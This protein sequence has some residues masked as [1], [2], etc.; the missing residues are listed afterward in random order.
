MKKSAKE[1]ASKVN[2]RF[3]RPFFPIEDWI[4]E[5]INDNNPVV[6]RGQL[7]QASLQCR[8]IEKAYHNIIIE[9]LDLAIEHANEDGKLVIKQVQE[10]HR[11]SLLDTVSQDDWL[12]AM[13][14]AEF[15][16]SLVRVLLQGCS[17]WEKMEV[18]QW[19]YAVGAAIWA[20]RYGMRVG[21]EATSAFVGLMWQ[22]ANSSGENERKNTSD[23]IA[24]IMTRNFG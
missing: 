7:Y 12:A 20:T 4:I 10:L 8:D 13:T 24:E 5:N 16:S 19:A 17:P 21:E 3:E 11:A 22:T 18:R 1:I 15:E 9:I 23:K 6:S 2:S 14:T